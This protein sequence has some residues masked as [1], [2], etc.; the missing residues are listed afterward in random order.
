MQRAPRHRSRGRAALVLVA[1]Q[2]WLL[3]S[4]APIPA[5]ADEISNVLVLEDDGTLLDPPRPLPLA[6]KRARFVPGRAGGYDTVVEALD[7][8]PT[9]WNRGR[10]LVFA[11]P[12]GTARISLATPFPFFGEA[13]S[14]VYVHPHGAVSLG[15]GL[16]S[17][18][19][20]QVASSG[21]LLRSL[22]AGPPVIAGLWNE[23]LPGRVDEASGV[24]VDEGTDRVSIAWVDVP[25]VRP[26]GEPNTFRITLHRDGRIDL[27]YAVMAARWGV[28]GLAPGHSSDQVAL[29]DIAT[30]PSGN[31]RQALLG[32]YRDLPTL[33][34]IALAR[35]A[36]RRLPDRFQFLTAF[37]TEPVDG[38]SMIASVPVKNLDRG[39]GLPVFDY[40]A[41]Y[42]SRNLEHLVVMNDVAFYDEDPTRPPRHPAY[43]FAPS[44]LAVLAHETGHR[45]LAE[46]SCPTGSL[47]S[48]EGHWSFFLESGGSLLGGNQLRDNGDGS[49]TTLE[50][51]RGFGPLDQYLMGL[52]PP[53]EVAPFFTVEGANSFDPAR[54][55][56]GQPFDE[57]S[58]PESGV[59][60][61]GTRRTITIG[62]VIGSTG[63]RSPS[64]GR[65]PRAFRMAFVL[66]VPAGMPPSAADL[67]KVERIRRAF[68]PFFQEA[69]GG[70]A[71]L[72]TALPFGIAPA[73][74]SDDARL[75]GGEPRVLEAE[76]RPRGFGRVALKLEFADFDADVTGV[77]LST[78]ASQTNPPT[79]VDVTT[80]AFGS[81]RGALT[82]NLYGIA[83][84]AR[85]LR[86]ALVDRRGQRSS[87]I[88][89][90][91]PVSKS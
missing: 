27:E 32:W 17:S 74:P 51:L 47:G 46:A 36:Y 34:E 89:R 82:V 1:V 77:E 19:R 59:R 72:G 31:A 66:V 44:T 22:T 80:A 53:E 79:A 60:F 90:P 26:A 45:W 7:G 55:A 21:E 50:P 13:Y 2:A 30:A 65:G 39:I 57:R 70:R 67:E 91:L 35:A 4:G 75:R 23:L 40:G 37:T 61:R 78:D 71:R 68:G 11:S 29:V 73:S 49:F 3:A 64:A 58:K 84:E 10:R 76:V 83:P 56:A 33:N 8:D 52:R 87:V 5:H 28:V 12:G 25:S 20:A 81:R 38:P 69:T 9:R 18:S 24:F 48:S 43:A 42:G 86:L 16:P 62:D 6:G 63:E 41:L 15:E 54:N 14:E 85:E 88:A